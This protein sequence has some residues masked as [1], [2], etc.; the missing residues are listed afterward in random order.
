MNDKFMKWFPLIHMKNEADKKGL[1][2]SDLNSTLALTMMKK[3]NALTNIL[4]VNEGVEKAEAEM[5]LSTA[6]TELVKSRVA[7]NEANAALQGVIDERNQALADAA[8]LQNSLNE[9]NNQ[10]NELQVSN[11]KIQ[12][13]LDAALTAI[14]PINTEL[15]SVKTE[16]DQHKAFYTDVRDDLNSDSPEI[17]ALMRA[18][19]ESILLPHQIQ[20]F[21]DK[22]V[23]IDEESKGTYYSSQFGTIDNWLKT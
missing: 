11:Q 9:A 12:R 5:N 6:N 10:I 16:L 13:E 7:F 20:P 4:L 18:L 8:V 17:G 19:A 2:I 21:K 15:E 22:I 23:A 14:E 1:N 3:Q